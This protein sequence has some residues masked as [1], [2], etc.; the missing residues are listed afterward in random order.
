MRTALLVLLL[1]WFSI[2]APSK[3][4]F[5]GTYKVGDVL[6][7]LCQEFGCSFGASGEAVSMPIV[8]S[9]KTSSPTVL[10]SSIRSALAMSGYYL[11]GD[12]K[13]SL[14]I[15]KDFSE[16]QGAFVTSSNEVAL[17][18]KHLLPYYKKA[19]SLKALAVQSE[20]WN[21]QYINVSKTALSSYG[22]DISH[23][24]AY[25]ET[26]SFNLFDSWNFDYLS[27]QDSLFE[28]RNIHFDL[29]SSAV[30]SWG[31]QKQ[32]PKQTFTQETNIVTSYEWRQYGIDIDVRRFPSYRLSYTI[33]SEDESTITGAS[34][35]SSD[36]TILLIAN[37]NSASLSE[38]CFLPWLPIFCKPTNKQ[39]TRY[40]I[41][42]MYRRKLER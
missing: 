30:F 5:N 26:F 34:G 37:Y 19:D 38:K 15:S 7:E 29:D 36:S 17:Y 23:P 16:N 4:V 2:A 8:L 33:R 31:T 28:I 39:E 3:Y 21:I 11:Y 14:K 6:S 24:L 10:L 18:P 9:L 20:R 40:I 12:F 41:I 35:L 22:F 13:S 42:R 27:S 1:S 25:G 32:I